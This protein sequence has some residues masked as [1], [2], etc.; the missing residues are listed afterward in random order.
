MKSP[1]I[2]LTA[3]AGSFDKIAA[4]GFITTSIKLQK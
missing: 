1:D 3:D 2:F 4:E